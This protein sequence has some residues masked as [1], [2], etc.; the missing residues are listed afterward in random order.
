MTRYAVDATSVVEVVVPA[1]LED[2]VSGGI[3]LK[4]LSV[5]LG[6]SAESRPG[7]GVVLDVSPTL[8][9]RIRKVEEVADV[10]QAP[11]FLLPPALKTLIAPRV[12]GAIL[13]KERLYLELGE[14]DALGRHP[15]A[16]HP[17]RAESGPRS[18]LPS[19]PAD[20]ALIFESGGR[21][22][23]VGLPMVSQV[24]RATEAYCP[25]PLVHGPVCGVFPHAQSL[26]PVYS[27]PVLFGSALSRT[28]S[29]PSVEHPDENLLVLTE[30][31]GLSVG[32]CASKVLGIRDRFEAGEREGEYLASGVQAPI[33]FPDLQG[34]FS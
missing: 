8:A 28:A 3:E 19:P 27:A 5:L 20:R 12:R 6:G 1:P 22:Y 2:R 33:T 17:A 32:F 7:A 29:E 34:E 10:A 11:L 14:L 13:Y 31:M 4:D 15:I 18:S 9:V 23:G 21:L 16:S 25:F 24:V 30:V 26:W